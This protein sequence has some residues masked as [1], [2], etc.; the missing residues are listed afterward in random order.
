MA[1]RKQML[2][3]LIGFASVPALAGVEP[4]ICVTDHSIVAIARGQGEFQC[5][6]P[7]KKDKVMVSIN[8]IYAAGYRVV[9]AA[10]ERFGSL[11]GYTTIFLERIVPDVPGSAGQGQDQ[12]K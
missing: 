11:G 12:T 6:T 4:N 10:Q 8:E 1:F 7:I 5:S 3:A 2:A 9:A